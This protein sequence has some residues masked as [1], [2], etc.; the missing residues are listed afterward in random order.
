MHQLLRTTGAQGI[1]NPRMPVCAHL[2]CANKCVNK[3]LGGGGGAQFGISSSAVYRSSPSHR[4]DIAKSAQRVVRSRPLGQPHVADAEGQRPQHFGLV[5]SALQQHVRRLH[6]PVDD[7]V[8][9]Q[10]RCR[11]KRRVSEATAAQV[12]PALRCTSCTSCTS[13][14]CS[15]SASC[16]CSGEGNNNCSTTSS[17]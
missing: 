2:S 7:I 15:C 4:P 14:W 1:P 9:V 3:C 5:F 13:C 16:S 6:V 8:L 10:M 17:L 11:H 12:Q